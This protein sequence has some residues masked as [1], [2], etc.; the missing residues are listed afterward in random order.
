MI[1]CHVDVCVQLIVLLLYFV[2]EYRS[3]GGR[4]WRV[5]GG[6]GIKPGDHNCSDA[7]LRVRNV[8]CSGFP[9]CVMS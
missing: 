1:T 6:T 5:R 4:L 8:P 9:K 2:E 3:L 7:I